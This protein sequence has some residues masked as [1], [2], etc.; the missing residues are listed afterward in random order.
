M[1]LYITHIFILP[2]GTRCWDCTQRQEKGCY[3]TLT[4][5]HPEDSVINTAPCRPIRSKPS[6]INVTER[7]LKFSLSTFLHIGQPWAQD[8]PVWAL[9]LQGQQDGDPGGWCAH[10]LGARLLWQSGQREG[11]RRIVS[12]STC[13]HFQPTKNIRI[14]ANWT[15]TQSIGFCPGWRFRGGE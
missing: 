9:W 12:T 7:L 2:H 11:A 8:L 13:T 1:N 10:P 5:C 3:S 14:N 6:V 4:K 15:S